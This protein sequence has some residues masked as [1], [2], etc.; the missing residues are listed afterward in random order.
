MILGKN[1]NI[2]LQRNPL[3]KFFINFTKISLKNSHYHSRLLNNELLRIASQESNNARETKSPVRCCKQTSMPDWRSHSYLHKPI[4]KCS[5]MCR[6]SDSSAL[7]Q[8]GVRLPHVVE[9][10]RIPGC[11]KEIY[12]LGPDI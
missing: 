6:R 4:I 11:I 2:I 5:T 1:F 9:C 3:H 7:H 12:N 8:N 10:D